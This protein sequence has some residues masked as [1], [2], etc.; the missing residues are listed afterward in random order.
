[1]TIKNG[2][3][4]EPSGG[5]AAPPYTKEKYSWDSDVDFQGNVRLNTN[6]QA[7]VEPY[8]QR[9]GLNASV[10]VAF[11][12]NF[13]ILGTNAAEANVT[14]DTGRAGIKCATAGADNDQLIVLP[15]LD[16]NQT[17]W[18]GTP[19]GTENQV[20]WEAIITSGDDITTGVLYWAGLKLTSD[21]T[22]ATDDDQ[23]YFRFSTDDSDTNWELVYS[24]GDVDTTADS[25]IAVAADTQYKLRIE[26]DSSRK[27]HFYINDTEVGISTALTNDINLIPYVGIQALSGTAEFLILQRQSISRI[28]YE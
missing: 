5:V 7:L 12:L 14:F 25:G 2:L 19:W 11:N 21:P 13:E 8:I 4:T 16:T 22:V 15:H 1:M 20:I 10:G 18:T 23:V 27:A 6:S 3:R 17:A 9:P 26:L 24:I 28:W